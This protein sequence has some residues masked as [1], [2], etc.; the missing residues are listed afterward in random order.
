MTKIA[1]FKNF[2][3]QLYT[4]IYLGH[5]TCSKLFAEVGGKSSLHFHREHILLKLGLK[6]Y[7]E[8]L[9]LNITA[10]LF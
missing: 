8:K 5:I 9:I 7:C 10:G 4:E 6:V 3:K 2:G 1:I